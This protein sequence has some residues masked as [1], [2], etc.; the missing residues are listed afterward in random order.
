[1]EIWVQNLVETGVFEMTGSGEAGWSA[2]EV[3]HE[4]FER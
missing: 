1:M 4:C 3:V 2:E